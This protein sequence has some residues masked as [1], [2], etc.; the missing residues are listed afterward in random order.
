MLG[1]GNYDMKLPIVIAVIG[2]AIGASFCFAL[3]LLL[4]RL[5][6]KTGQKHLSPEK[7]NKASRIFSRFFMILLPFTWIVLFNFLPLIAAFLGKRARIVLPL[8]IL[9]KIGYYGFCVKTGKPI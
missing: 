4:K 3:G 9:G 5:Y 1:F 8:V 6:F 2:S 7:Y